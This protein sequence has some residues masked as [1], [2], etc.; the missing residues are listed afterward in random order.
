MYKASLARTGQLASLRSTTQRQPCKGK[1]AWRPEWPQI[2]ARGAVMVRLAELILPPLGFHG[3]ARR[4]TWWLALGLLILVPMPLLPLSFELSGITL[5]ILLLN[6]VATTV[7]RAHDLD[8]Y[9]LLPVLSLLVPLVVLGAVAAALEGM[10]T[11]SPSTMVPLLLTL[12]LIPQ[13]FALMARRGTAGPNRFGER[14][15]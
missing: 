14:A 1:R 15:W 6:L 11:T 9:A 4:R 5:L 8:A 3:R 7:R 10:P 2:A 13:L 12:L